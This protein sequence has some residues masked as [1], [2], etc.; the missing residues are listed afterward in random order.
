ME[1]LIPYC[2]YLPEEHIK[3]LKKMAKSR[4]ASEFVR[5]AV[6]MAMDKTD[7]FSSGYNKGL[8]D[9]CAIINDNKEAKM[10]A[11][12]SRYLCDILGDQIRK[13]RHEPK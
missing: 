9:A 12:K 3:K 4:K 8:T 2:L 1:K 11:I 6:V 5:N 10:V 7:E 13:L